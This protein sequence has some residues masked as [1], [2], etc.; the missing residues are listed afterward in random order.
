MEKGNILSREELLSLAE[1]CHLALGEEE[2]QT[3]AASLSDMLALAD[4]LRRAD[5]S[6][7]PYRG[8]QELGLSELRADE[9]GE[10]LPREVLLA[11]AK[12]TA[13]GFFRVPRVM[14]EEC[15]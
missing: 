4:R 2:L 3:L 5:R 6:V 15:V 10:S 7:P 1:A 12:D 14:E 11:Q 9:S 13:D 8:T